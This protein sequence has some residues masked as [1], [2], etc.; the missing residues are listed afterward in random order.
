MPHSHGPL[1]RE[2]EFPRRASI[3]GPILALIAAVMVTFMTALAITARPPRQ[4]RPRHID[5]RT[6]P[7][8]APVLAPAT[9]TPPPAICG[10]KVYRA[11]PD[12]R[13]EQFEDCAAVVR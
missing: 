8:L 13:A 9:V 11:N 5:H 3:A 7:V 4:A 1:V 10:Q 6:E 2:V 12:G